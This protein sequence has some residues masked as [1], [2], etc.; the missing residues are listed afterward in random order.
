MP[1]KRKEAP[2]AAAAKKSEQH[3]PVA[4]EAPGYAD[5][6]DP[7][8]ATDAAPDAGYK[9]PAWQEMTTYTAGARLTH[10]REKGVYRIHFNP[11][12]DQVEFKAFFREKIKPL[13]T[14]DHKL[15]G[16]SHHSFLL[17]SRQP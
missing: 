12:M 15:K 4:A 16:G 10:D 14:G 3:R 5:G 6:T 1:A 13:L 11:K 8:T 2:T 17:R 7:T 9:L